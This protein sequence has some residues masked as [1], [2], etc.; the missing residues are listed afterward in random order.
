MFLDK[1][2][3]K[4]NNVNIGPYLLQIEFG[5]NKLWADDTGRNMLG[6]MSGTFLGIVPKFKL[7]F[8]KL[9][10]NELEIIAPIINSPWQSTTYYDPDLRRNNTID[11][12]TGD[13]N[14]LNKST[15]EDNYKANESFD[16]SVIG[17]EPMED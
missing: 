15:F 12:Y 10:K 5:W 9:T 17:V 13:W 1:D 14:T 2:S 3:F 4:I 16:I 7:T 11:T 6:A 8:R